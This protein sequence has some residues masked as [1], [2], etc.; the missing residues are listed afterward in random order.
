M[1]AWVERRIIGTGAGLALGGISLL[2]IRTRYESAL[3]QNASFRRYMAIAGL[4]RELCADGAL[5]RP[6]R[7][8]I[9]RCRQG[10]A[11]CAARSRRAAIH[12]KVRARMNIRKSRWRSLRRGRFSNYT[13][14]LLGYK[15]FPGPAANSTGIYTNPDGQ[16]TRAVQYCGHCERFICEAQ[17]KG[18]SGCAVVS[19]AVASER[20]LKSACV[21]MCSA[22]ITTPRPGVRRACV[23]WIW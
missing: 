2:R 6:V 14:E 4:G 10:R 12:L 21:R 5:S 22:S 18:H 13:A 17:A 19:A 1:R 7:E 20:I 16:E 9:R 15:P 11:I 8:I 3:W 23:M